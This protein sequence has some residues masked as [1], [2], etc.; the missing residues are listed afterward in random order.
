MGCVVLCCLFLCVV[1]CMLRVACCVLCFSA[2]LAQP[3]S[4]PSQLCA[5]VPLMP[6]R[7]FARHTPHPWT[8]KAGSPC[9]PDFLQ[10]FIQTLVYECCRKSDD[11]FLR[12][13]SSASHI[14]R[15]AHKQPGQLS[16]VTQP[17]CR[18]SQQPQG[19]GV[20]AS[21]KCYVTCFFCY[22]T[23]FSPPK[24]VRTRYMNHKWTLRN[25]QQNVT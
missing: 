23:C 11:T 3:A 4:S 20:L 17:A 16:K 21:R 9:K 14:Q 1:S 5:S 10:I 22:V 7:V 6:Q 8:P 24:T 19:S 13:A 15:S 18:R 12:F 2:S 25:K